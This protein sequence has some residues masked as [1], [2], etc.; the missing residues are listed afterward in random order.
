MFFFRARTRTTLMHHVTHPDP[1]TWSS[2]DPGS[3]CLICGSSGSRISGIRI[4]GSRMS[5]SRMYG[6]GDFRVPDRTDIAPEFPASAY[7]GA[8]YPG[9]GYLFVGGCGIRMSNLWF[10]LGAECISGSRISGSRISV[11]R[12]S[13][14]RMPEVPPAY[15]PPPTLLKLIHMKIEKT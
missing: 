7:P 9:S 8:G 6:A 13:A 15:P 12:I 1:D 2:A 4:S 5:G 11:T 3:E 10:M 14:S